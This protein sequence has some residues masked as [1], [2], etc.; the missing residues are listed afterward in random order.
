LN[1]Q[2]QDWWIDWGGSVSLVQEISGKRL[3]HPVEL[4]YPDKH[5]RFKPR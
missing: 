1:R 4:F 3:E 2:Q 5:R